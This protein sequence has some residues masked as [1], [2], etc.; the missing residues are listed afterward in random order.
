[1]ED[2]IQNVLV[3]EDD[4][5]DF[6]ILADVIKDRSVKVLVTHAENGDIL[7]RMIHEKIPDLLFLDVVMPCRDGKACIKEIRADKK[8]DGLPVIIYTSVRDMDTVEFCFR[9][10]SNMY[11]LK[12]ETYSE[13]VDVVDKI[14]SVQWKKLQYYPTRSGFILNPD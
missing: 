4:K 10:G 9:N 12:P 5:D 1:M 3:A 14:F 11:V 7:M 2:E 6:E 13:I 8:F